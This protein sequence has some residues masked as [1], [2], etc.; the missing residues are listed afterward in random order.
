MSVQGQHPLTTGGLQA[1][2]FQWRHSGNKVYVVAAG[3]SPYCGRPRLR[4]E[5]QL[6][7][8]TSRCRTRETMIE[9]VILS[10]S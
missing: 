4:R 3:V 8:D 7:P 9:F 10:G 6:H 5:R 1:S 2:E